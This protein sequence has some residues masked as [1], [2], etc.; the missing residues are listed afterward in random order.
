MIVLRNG[1][2]L[3]D[4]MKRERLTLDDLKEAARLKGIGSLNDVEYAVLESDGE[5][6]FVTRE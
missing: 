6:S 2:P 3:F 1:E 5:F 4:R